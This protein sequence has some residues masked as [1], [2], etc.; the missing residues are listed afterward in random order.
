MADVDLS[1]NYHSLRLYVGTFTYKNV[2]YRIGNDTSTIRD[3]TEK[4]Y[5]TWDDFHLIP[6][7]RPTVALPPANTKIITVPGR[8]DPIDFSDYL[9]GHT[10]YGNRTGSWSFY[11]NPEYVDNYLGGWINFDK[12]LRTLFHGHIRKVSLRDDPAYFYV[13]EIS[14]G[15]WQPGDSY[16]SVTFSYN[17]YPFKKSMISSMDLWKW[18]EF[19]FVDG[20]IMYLKDMEVDGSRTVTI[21]GGKERISPY[22]SG[23][24]GLTI[25]KR[26]GS[27]WQ[28]YGDVPTSS[29]S[30]NKSIIPGLVIDS[31]EN[32]LRFRGNG[33][34]TVDYRRG[35]L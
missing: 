33:T 3:E 4:F 15:E 30:S 17:F 8:K 31:G 26:E 24:R 28:S 18:D 22:I 34:V 6:T 10:T 35:M 29:I 20:V 25:E 21:Y 5:D 7:E 1:L 27:N 32:R 23:S 2:S 19:D 16:S 12:R 14:M 13:G 11:T 9:T